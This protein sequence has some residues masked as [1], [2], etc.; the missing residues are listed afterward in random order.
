MEIDFSKITVYE[1]IALFLS[2][3][4]IMIPIVQWAWNRWL[5]KPVLNHLTTGKINPCFNRSGSYLRIESV[6]EAVNKPITV[7]HIAL[8]LIRCRDEKKLNQVWSS[9]WSPITQNFSGK[10]TST[11]EGAHPFRIEKNSITTAFTEFEDLSNTLQRSLSE[12][13]RDVDF[14][15]KDCLGQMLPYSETIAR[16]EKQTFYKNMK[17]AL[18][19]E[20]FWDIGKYKAE[21]VVKYDDSE[22]TF[23]YSFVINEVEYNKLK[24]N[25]EETLLSP[26]KQA[27]NMLFDFQ[28]VSLKLDV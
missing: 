9:F 19:K 16:F 20:F 2:F 23:S 21:I 15:V 5:V 10:Y 25:V 1:V 13:D 3:I 4:A 6:Y 12:F 18:M 17:D 8:K 14:F 24:H 22:K 26:I 11:I 27:Y 28:V 7:K